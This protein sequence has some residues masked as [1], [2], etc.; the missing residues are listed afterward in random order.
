MDT[1]RISLLG[2]PQLEL[3]G[4]QIQDFTYRKSFALLFYLALNPGAHTRHALAGLLWGEM[5]DAR[6]LAALSRSLSDL[7]KQ[8]GDYLDI[9]PHSIAFDQNVP[10]WLDVEVFECNIHAGLEDLGPADPEA[11]HALREALALYRGELLEGFSVRGAVAFEETVTIA[12]ERLYLLAIQALRRLVDYDVQKGALNRGI[13]DALQLL[14]LEPTDEETHAQLMILYAHSGQRSAALRQYEACQEILDAELGIPPAAETTTL[15]QKI[16]ENKFGPEDA[17]QPSPSLFDLNL[18]SS[19]SRLHNLPVE[20]TP[21]FGKSTEIEKLVGLLVNPDY[22]LISLVGEG[23]VGKTRLAIAVARK[24]VDEFPQGVWFVPLA[25]R[26]PGNLIDPNA[27]AL[28]QDILPTTDLNNHAALV[29]TAIADTL[30]LPLQGPDSPKTQVQNHLRRWRAVLILDN[31]EHLQEGIADYL[32]EMLNKAPEVT[33]LVTSRQRLNLQAE[34]MIRIQGLPYPKTKGLSQA[35]QPPLEPLNLEAAIQFDSLRLFAERARRIQTNFDLAENNF[36]EVSEI[37]QLL[38]GIPLGIE[39]AAA[40]AEKMEPAEVRTAIQNNLDILETTMQD[41]PRRQRSLRAVFDGSWDLLPEN[42]KQVLARLSVFRGTFTSMAALS[43]VQATDKVLSSLASKSLIQPMAINRYRWHE[44]PRTFASEKL[45][46]SPI[47]DVQRVRDQHCRYFLEMVRRGESIDTD[48]TP[49]E[50]AGALWDQI[51]NIRQAWEWGINQGFWDQIATSYKGL[52]QVYTFRSRFQEGETACR[53]A[54]DQLRFLLADPRKFS[55]MDHEV[56]LDELLSG[57]LIEQGR[58]LNRL[59]Q[60]EKAIEIAR[61]VSERLQENLSTELSALNQLIWGAALY[62]QGA[63]PEA[64]QKLETTRALARELEFPQL[65]AESDYYL[66]LAYKEQ[67]RYELANQSLLNANQLYQLENNQL[68][69]IETL[70]GLGL[71]AHGHGEYPEAGTYFQE[72]LEVTRR[73][74]IPHEQ[75]RILNS[76]GTIREM[77]TEYSLAHDYYMQSLRIAEFINDRRILSQVVMNLGVLFSRVG[78]YEQALPHYERSLHIKRELG[79]RRGEAW[80]LANLGLLYHRIGEHQT[81]LDLHYRMLDIACQLGSRSTEGIAHARIG[82]D[83]LG[84]RRFAEAEDSFRKGLAIQQE[85]GQ[86]HWAAETMAGLLN[87]SLEKGKVSEEHEC[88]DQ[89][90]VLLETRGTVGM[91]EPFVVY[92]ICFRALHLLS[93][94]RAYEVLRIAHQALQFTAKKITDDKMRRSFLSNVAAHA[95]IAEEW[96]ALG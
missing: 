7:R 54:A 89:I 37:C 53:E 65:E 91:R 39:L 61:S 82:Q 4:K 55:A 95:E 34:M 16:L 6:A 12:R 56:C 15:Y 69:L 40:L 73:L 9:E 63:Y 45:S 81:A 74:D 44:V 83:L 59:G 8:V 38:E 11:V 26:T 21:F 43:V 90:L 96:K 80:S 28:N 18:V 60:Y 87:I 92:L 52:F 77:Q 67:S 84:Q 31:L 14:A 24:V 62:F 51:Q 72:A 85:L 36:E 79:S 10:Y 47:Q 48:E 33:L 70:Y 64:Y 5:S 17:R 2:K 58:F 46:A 49:Q 42:E 86:D 19:G 29:A 93:D 66:G 68:G 76:L 41:V 3:R 27:G 75:C 1:L 20:T 35:E 30:K 94:K 78:M 71:T 32:L 13:L 23:G 88:I 25:E 57:L 22:R 50:I